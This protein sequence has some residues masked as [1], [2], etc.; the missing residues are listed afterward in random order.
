V[1]RYDIRHATPADLDALVDMRLALQAHL[2]RRNASLWT[3]REESATAHIRRQVEEALGDSD[4]VTLVACEGDG[5]P[6]GMLTGQ[7]R[8]QPYRKP[9][10]IG[11]I[12]LFYVQ[13]RWRRQGVGRSLVQRLCLFFSG[14]DVEEI[15]LRYVI[16][17]IEAEQFW[18]TLGF[19]PR[20]ITAGTTLQELTQHL[21]LS[22]STADSKPKRR[23][24]TMIDTIL[25]RRSIRQYTEEAVSDDDIQ[26]LLEAAMA[27]PSASN[28]KPWHFVVVTERAKLDAL[29]E[30]LPYG[31]MLAHAPLAVAVCGDPEISPKYWVQDTSAATENLLLAVASLGLGAVWLGVEPNE[32]RRDAVAEV[33]DIPDNIGIL[34]VIS[35][36]HPAEEKPARTQF[37]A[38][39]VHRESW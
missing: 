21:E 24:A 3:L 4:E 34:N 29:A 37:D 11:F 2:E 12:N 5:I 38:Q 9:S 31:K 8:D 27:A 30:A 33:L 20:I 17:N 26:Q 16:G 23:N 28:R 7:V 39:R 15:S 6:F 14:E 10:R 32:D 19:Q 36:G 25:E 18:T 13:E 1:K 35:I 22:D